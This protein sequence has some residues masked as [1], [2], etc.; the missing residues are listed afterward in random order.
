MTG[1]D[2]VVH[3]A[4]FASPSPQGKFVQL[5][6]EEREVWLFSSPRVH[7]FH[8]QI[9][10]WF[11]ADQGLPLQWADPNQAGADGRPLRILGGGRYVLNPAG[12]EIVLSG[13]SSAYGRFIAEGFGE[14]LAAASHPWSRLRPRIG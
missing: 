4:A 8:T 5:L 14:K 1:P 7:R 11:C 2:I 12:G 6:W 10:E 9:V 13:D 3:S